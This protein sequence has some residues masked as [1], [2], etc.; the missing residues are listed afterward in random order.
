MANPTLVQLATTTVGSGGVS[1]V[2]FSSIPQTYTDLKLVVSGK[3][4]Y[5]GAAYD[6]GYVGFN[7]VTTNLSFIRLQG[8]GSAASSTSGTGGIFFRANASGTGS[9]NTFGNAEIYIPNYTGSTNKSASVDSV[10]ENNG[11]EAYTG[12]FAGLWSSTA[13]ITS[14]TAYPNNGNWAQYSTFYLYG[15]KNS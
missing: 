15:I 3:T 6:L 12:L 10:E 11:T 1:S 9:T 8:S 2:T 13:A 5:T 14:L 7:G 4:D